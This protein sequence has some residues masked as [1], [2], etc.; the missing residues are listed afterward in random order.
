I[1]IYKSAT[2][3]TKN[4]TRWIAE[5]VSADL[6]ALADVMPKKALTYDC[7]IFGGRLPSSRSSTGSSP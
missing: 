2:G 1:V 6:F 7:I 4:Y 5:A 3:F